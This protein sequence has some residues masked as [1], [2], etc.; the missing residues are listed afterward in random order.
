M[1]PFLNPAGWFLLV[2]IG[3]KTS[4]ATTT[5]T[6]VKADLEKLRWMEGNWKGMDGATAF[7]EQYIF[8]NDSTMEITSYEDND[9]SSRS[10]TYFTWKHDHYFLGDSLNWRVDALT[11]NSVFLI[12][13]YKAVNKILWQKKNKDSWEAVL[14]SP[15]GVKTYRMERLNP[16]LTPR[17]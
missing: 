9:K 5:N 7:Y 17:Q 10:K 13:N 12:P 15:K 2:V 11:R 16:T 14:T 3:C 8:P 1:K 4:P 6:F